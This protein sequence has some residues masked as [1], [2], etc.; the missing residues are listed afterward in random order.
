MTDAT[1]L[2]EA[3]DKRRLELRLK[4]T[5]VAD[6]ADLSQAGLGAIR[7]GERSPSALTKARIEHALEWAPGSVDAILAGDDP[8]PGSATVSQAVLELQAERAQLSDSL[9]ELEALGARSSA[10][11]KILTEELERLD[12]RLKQADR[13]GHRLDQTGT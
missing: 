5:Q 7:R 8:A 10:A 9:A 3:M 11:Y 12:A 13:R 4:W 1:R 6:R 2:S